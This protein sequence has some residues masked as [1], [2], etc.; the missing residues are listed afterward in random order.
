MRHVGQPVFEGDLYARSALRDPYGSYRRIRDLGQAVWLPRRRM[1]AVGRFDDVKTA[2]RA[3]GVLVSGRGIAANGLLNHLVQPITLTSDGEVHKRRKSVLMH[4]LTASSLQE[5]RPRLEAEADRLVERLATGETFEAVSQLASH[6]P[7][8]VVAELVGLNPAGRKRMLVW[9]AATFNALGVMNLRGLG[10]L[11][12]LSSFALYSWR[13]R[14]EDLEPDGWARRLFDAAD[15]KGLTHKE[16]RAMLH[17]YVGPAL[18][19]TILATAHM[20]WLLATNSEAFEELRATPSLVPSVVN[21]AV[22]LASPIRGFTRYAAADFPLGEQVISKG[23]RALILFASANRDERQYAHPDAFDV[24]RNPR[25][26]VGWGH[27]QHVCAGMHLS[28]LEMELLLSAL[29]RHVSKIETDAPKPI[30]NNVLQGFQTL[31]TRLYPVRGS[32]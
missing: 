32:V 9:A 5:L 3:H 11:R 21:E 13:L 28:R 29:V 24:R 7:V 15:R 30:W 2:L 8:T 26:H 14:P 25:D 22:R 16:A 17:D 1:W 4:P 18:D 23:S 20:L 6:M 19:T 31:P 27:G 10:A 12:R